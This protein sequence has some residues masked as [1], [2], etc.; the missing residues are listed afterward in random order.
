MAEISAPASSRV[1]VLG[2]G[3]TIAM[4]ATGAGGG[5]TPSLTVEQLIAAVPGLADTGIH[6]DV[7][8]FRSRPSASLTFADLTDLAAAIRGHLQAGAAG[9]VVTQGTDSIEEAAYLLDLVHQRPEPVVVTGAMRNPT[10]AGADGPANLYA[11]VT[12]AASPAARGLGVLVVFADEIHAAHRVR[13]T[14][15]TSIATFVSPNG[16]PLGYHVEGTARIVNQLSSRLTIGQPSLL[17]TVRVSVIPAALWEDPAVLEAV[18]EHLHGLVVA[19]FGAGHVPDTWVNT[20]AKLA[21]TIPVVLA[22]R[23][24]AG[25]VLTGT[26]GFPGSERDL[27]GRGLIPAG[28]LDQY[29]ARILLHLC[30]AAGASRQ[31]IA[32]AFTAAGGTDPGAWPWQSPDAPAADAA[33]H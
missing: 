10:L 12:T 30:L 33:R 9:V 19:G 4:T 5:V 3:G 14:H 8:S 25:P 23:S 27:I 20:L 17:D 7:V 29:K 6:V 21:D 11:A 28:Y 16:G 24:G 18:A 13:K 15:S 32:A 31:Q 26:Y 1:V 22:S 2:L